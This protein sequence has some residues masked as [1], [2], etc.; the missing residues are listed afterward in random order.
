MSFKMF[1]FGIQLLA[2]FSVS[3]LAQSGEARDKNHPL[4]V[5]IYAPPRPAS[6]DSTHEPDH[7][8]RPDLPDQSGSSSRP[9]SEPT[10]AERQAATYY[11]EYQSFVTDFGAPNA[12]SNMVMA[13]NGDV[14]FSVRERFSRFGNR[15][16]YFQGTYG[17]EGHHYW[18][19]SS[20]G[21]SR[22]NPAQIVELIRTNL[23][24]VFPLMVVEGEQGQR[25][26]LN[27]ILHLR[28]LEGVF[29]DITVQV[30][31]T[32]PY[33]FTVTAR[34]H[35]LQGSATH[36]VFRD[37]TGELWLFHEGVGVPG[38]L[39]VKQKANAWIASY[40]WPQMGQKVRQLFVE[41]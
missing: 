24:Q 27:N 9:E 22:L 35:I 40:M 5:P 6:S 16:Y 15:D 21:R 29:G 26:A 18:S 31:K 28:G 13:H 2:V 34:D 3:V 30:T 36:G 1:R 32:T 25:V 8:D 39:H 33:F 38:E 23:D 17:P 37:K 12:L 10:A 7:P 14:S 20:L 4:E 19:F 41:P 11:H